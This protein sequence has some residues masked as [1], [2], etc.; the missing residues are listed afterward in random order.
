[1]RTPNAAT[2]PRFEAHLKTRSSGSRTHRT[3]VLYA[4]GKLIELPV[5]RVRRTRQVTIQLHGMQVRNNN[6]DNSLDPAT[7]PVVLLAPER[8]DKIASRAALRDRDLERAFR[9]ARVRTGGVV[10]LAAGLALLLAST[11]AP[12][13]E[14]PVEVRAP[15]DGVQ[16]VQPEPVTVLVETP[17]GVPPADV[18][19]SSF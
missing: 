11:S 1:M 17:T 9:W 19:A 6:S 5:R 15:Q 16:F 8:F 14:G 7:S 4:G 2:G 3:R 10:T 12:R 18:K 13:V